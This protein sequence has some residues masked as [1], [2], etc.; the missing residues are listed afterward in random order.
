MKKITYFY[1]L[2]V[3]IAGCTTIQGPVSGKKYLCPVGFVGEVPSDP[4]DYYY[5]RYSPKE[6]KNECRQHF[7]DAHPQTPEDIKQLIREGK[8]MNGMNREQVKASWGGPRDIIKTSGTSEKWFYE[9]RGPVLY[10]RDGLLT[11]WQKD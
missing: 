10:F 11:S 4:F 6:Y 2:A 3:F 1:V 8:I 7:L 5:F 9:E